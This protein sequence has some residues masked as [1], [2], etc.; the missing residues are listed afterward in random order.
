M[1]LP[2]YKEINQYAVDFIQNKTYFWPNSNFPLEQQIK[3]VLTSYGQQDISHNQFFKKLDFL[4]Q[5]YGLKLSNLL[6]NP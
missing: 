2:V 1:Y 3:H 5:F 6:V 4:K